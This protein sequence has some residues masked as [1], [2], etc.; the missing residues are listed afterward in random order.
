MSYRANRE[1]DENST[2]RR[3]RADSNYPAN[4]PCVDS[5]QSSQNFRKATSHLRPMAHDPSS[6]PA[7]VSGGRFPVPET[8]AENVGRVSCT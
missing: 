5:V 8:W 6:P 3:Y 1:N 4:M 7:Q 2:V